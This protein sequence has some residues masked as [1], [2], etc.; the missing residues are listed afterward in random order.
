MSTLT[1][2]FATIALTGAVAVTAFAPAAQAGQRHRDW[3]RGHGGYHHVRPY[4]PPRHYHQ[5]R[6]VHRRD[7]N[8]GAAIALGIGALAL[9]AVIAGSSN[10]NAPVYAAP[11]AYRGNGAATYSSIE[12]WTAAWYDY[13]SDRY[14][15]FNPSTGTFRG[16]DGY[17][18]FCVAR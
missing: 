3:Q 12:P 15:S 5:P 11:P 9:G 16:F 13:C 8:T 1:R 17:D 14:N 6:R 2:K 7:N 10:N 18:H 4:H